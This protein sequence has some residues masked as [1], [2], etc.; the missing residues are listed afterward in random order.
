MRLLKKSI[1]MSLRGSTFASLSVN[2]ATEA[3]LAGRQAISKKVLLRPFGIPNRTS[4][5]CLILGLD[6]GLGVNQ[7]LEIS[8]ELSFVKG[9]FESSI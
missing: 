1:S 3:C 7:G 4:T 8:S 6:L 5:I 2:S 9:M